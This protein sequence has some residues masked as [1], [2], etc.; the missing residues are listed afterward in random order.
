[1]RAG[2]AAR[3]AYS[4]RLPAS[5]SSL[6]RAAA[7]GSAYWVMAVAL[8]FGVQRLREQWPGPLKP[9]GRDRTSSCVKTLPGFSFE[10]ATMAQLRHPPSWRRS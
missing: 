1:V 5:G 10:P 8:S 6:W 2:G 3:C 4:T 9:S 7:S